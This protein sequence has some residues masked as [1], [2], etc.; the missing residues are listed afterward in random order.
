MAERRGAGEMN[1]QRRTW[2]RD[3]YEKRAKERVEKEVSG[4]ALKED[5]AAV[6]APLR[7][8][9]RVPPAVM[10]GDRSPHGQIRMSTITL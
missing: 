8:H 9:D 7:A 5:K 10:R 3:E 1:V 2:D 4:E 6:R